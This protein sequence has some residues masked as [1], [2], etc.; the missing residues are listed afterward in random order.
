VTQPARD[1]PSL[2]IIVTGG[3][4]VLV[5]IAFV[6]GVLLG[7]TGEAEPGDRV[8]IGRTDDG[9]LVVFAARCEDERVRAVEV[10]T[11]GGPPAWR[12]E[13]DKGTIDRRFVVGAEPP[14]FFATRVALDGPLP[15][16]VLEAEVT[17]DD[18][19]DARPFDPAALEDG[20]SFGVSCDDGDLGLVPIVFVL[21]AMGVIG[22]YLAMVAR[23]VR[24]P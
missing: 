20:E 8:G 18:V 21:G 10:R 19:V 11:P 14:A 24:R 12:I 3:I 23:F 15:D 17:I 5:V 7:R 6:A 22:A 13:S 4:G 1:V 9:T 2:G 16:G